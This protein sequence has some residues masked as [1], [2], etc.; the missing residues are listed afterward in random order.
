MND[1]EQQGTAK[2]LSYGQ[3]ILPYNVPRINQGVMT[4]EKPIENIQRESIILSE[5]QMLQLMKSIKIGVYKQLCANGMIT[6][7]QFIQLLKET[8]Y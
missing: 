6:N 8:E 2:H 1:L 3:S 7:S 5:K 4:M